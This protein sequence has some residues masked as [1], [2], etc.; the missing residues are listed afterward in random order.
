M[1]LIKAWVGAAFRGFDK[2]L[3]I[4]VMYGVLWSIWKTRNRI[5]FESFKPNWE[6]EIMQTK[7][8]LDKGV[9]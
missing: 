5:I 7:I 1:D 8:Q 3:W 6:F 2:Q 9:V 4:S